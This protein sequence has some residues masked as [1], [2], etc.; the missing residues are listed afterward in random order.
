ML[1]TQRQTVGP[2]A[3]IC[4]FMVF[5]VINKCKQK[6]DDFRILASH[7]KKAKIKK[8]LWLV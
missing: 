5:F 1:L 6:S 3:E 2:I 4:Q 7:Y 8:F